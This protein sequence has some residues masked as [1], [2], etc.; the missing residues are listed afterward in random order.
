[1]TADAVQRAVGATP[2]ERGVSRSR[3]GMTG[4]QLA[5]QAPSSDPLIIHT[6][7]ARID[8][9]WDDAVG[10]LPGGDLIQTTR[11][12]AARQRIGIQV[13]HLRLCASD[14]TLLAGGLIQCRRVMPGLGIGAVPRGP[15]LF[16]EDPGLADRL[17]QELVLM[18]RRVGIDLLVVQPSVGGEEALDRAMRAAGF[19]PG[20]PTLAADAS[21]R[22][23]LR[24]S[25]EDILRRAHSRRRTHIRNAL[26]SPLKWRLSDDVATFHALHVA[27]AHRTGFRPIELTALQAQWDI[28]APAGMCQIIEVRDDGVPIEAEWLT[29]FAG[30]VTSK[31]KGRAYNK[32]PV[33]AA[34]KVAGTA[35][36]WHAIGWARSMGAQYFDF[37]GFERPA[38]EAL[39]RSGSTKT[40]LPAPCQIKWSFGGEVFLLPQAQFLLTNQLLQPVLSGLVPPLLNNQ[41]L[42]R[43]VQRLRVW[44]GG[45][46]LGTGAA[47]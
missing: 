11:W 5:A 30:T 26:R 25:E 27:S 29:C 9:A 31:L 39:L 23:D 4:G 20:G 3:R 19:R 1:M 6:G 2:P 18:A 34:S 15:L 44:V 10:R 36:L 47:T 42:R 38:A 13:H 40:D 32:G 17:M 33:T 8:P 46:G 24:Q 37:G 28:L 35:A 43:C 16:T 14:G 45:T 41:R 12:A 22:I 7:E 21:I